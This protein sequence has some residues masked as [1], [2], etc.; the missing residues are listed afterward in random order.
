MHKTNSIIMKA[1][2]MSIFETA[3]N[4]AAL[5]LHPLLGAR[6]KSECSGDGGAAFRHADQMD[7]RANHRPR[8]SRNSL[9]SPE[10]VQQRDASGVDIRSKAG[11][12]AREDRA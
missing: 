4:L 10:G 11:W 3:A 12:R 9:S 8:P 7:F 2:R 1:P 6:S 5:S